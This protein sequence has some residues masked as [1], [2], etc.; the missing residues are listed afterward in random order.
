MCTYGASRT[1]PERVGAQTSMQP[2][3][4]TGLVHRKTTEMRVDEGIEPSA[5]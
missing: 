5:E 1:L 2:W 4:G 3:R